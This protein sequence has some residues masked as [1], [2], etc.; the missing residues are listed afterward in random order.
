MENQD[1]INFLFN[2][3]VEDNIFLIED[4]ELHRLDNNAIIANKEILEFIDKRVHPKSR[5][6]LKKLL[7]NYDN[8][9]YLSI[10][11]ENEL[12]YKYGIS[13]GIKF[14]LAA[15]STK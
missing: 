14:I 7:I 10:A 1:I 3:K 6:K 5:K 12:Y 8:A 9:K 13:D 4:N 15:L 2:K 11:R